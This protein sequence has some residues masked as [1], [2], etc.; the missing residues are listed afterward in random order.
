MTRK[1]TSLFSQ[2]ITLIIDAGEFRRI[3][4]A[5]KGD[6]HS[7]G[8]RCR[9]QPVALLFLHLS[10]V[11]SLREITH[12]LRT[13]AGKIAHLG[14]K[15]VPGHST[16]SY[17]NA[18]RPSVMYRSLLF[19]ALER[20]QSQFRT[21]TSLRFKNKLLS[22]DAT[23]ID[24][25]LSLFPWAKFRQTKGAV[26]V[27]LLLD[28]DGYFPVFAH[29]TDGKRADALVVWVVD[30]Q[31]CFHGAIDAVYKRRYTFLA[32]SSLPRTDV[33]TGFTSFFSIGCV[34]RRSA[35]GGSCGGDESVQ[36]MLFLIA[37]RYNHKRFGQ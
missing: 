7:K 36:I 15:K 22:M 3:V 10:N 19:A 35:R 31:P 14:M 1:A 30:V 32:R 33:G 21:G 6:K 18:H 29:I 25:G 5:S 26:K 13:V 20:F 17:A 23:T 4:E 12:G 8:L 9:E 37:I 34:R 11:T 27:H 2:I 16:L 24:L 28:H